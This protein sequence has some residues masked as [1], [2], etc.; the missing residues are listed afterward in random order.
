MSL[1]EMA[2]IPCRLRVAFGFGSGLGTT[3]K[4]VPSHCS[5]SPWGQ[6][7][8]SNFPIPTPQ[9]S[10][11]E[12]AVTAWSEEKPWRKIG[13]LTW[14]QL[15]PSK[16]RTVGLFV[17]AQMS[18]LA[19]AEM[20]KTPSGPVKAGLETTL[21][22]VPSQ[23]SIKLTSDPEELMVDPPAQT[24]FDEMA[25][26]A[27]RNPPFLRFGLETT[28]Q[29]VPFQFSINGL[30]PAVSSCEP[31]AHT[32]F[33]ATAATPAREEPPLGEG[34]GMTLQLVPLKCTGRVAAGFVVVCMPVKPTAQISLSA[35]AVVAA[36]DALLNCA[37][38]WKPVLVAGAAAGVA[39]P[40]CLEWTPS[41]MAAWCSRMGW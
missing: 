5:I 26:T 35:S 30:L 20:P 9:T 3:L 19:S 21:Q 40:W 22:L 31:T 17:T 36:K 28:L 14:L 27:L 25:V 4:L 33:L 8:L 38:T 7:R 1:A 29:L 2:A 41:T 23:C 24:L 12:S 16:C 13:V 34:V 10:D 6:Q 11:G 32:S 37:T 15:V 39:V 18:L